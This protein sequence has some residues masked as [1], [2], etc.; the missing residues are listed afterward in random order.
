[1]K[2]E[3]CTPARRSWFIVHRSS[4][5]LA[6]FRLRRGVVPRL[7]G[8]VDGDG[9]D[10]TQ[11]EDARSHDLFTRFD[12]GEHTDLIATRAAQLHELL[13][14]TAIALAFWTLDVFDDEHG[15]TERRVA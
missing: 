15:I 1:M 2:D 3:R 12:S 13:A 4:L 6:V 11:F 5:R 9:G 14:D 8:V 10:R 7:N